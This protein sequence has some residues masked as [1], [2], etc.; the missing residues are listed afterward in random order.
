MIGVFYVFLQS[1][2]VN[3]RR[4][5]GLCH[6]RFLPNPFLFV[7]YESSYC[8]TVYG[9]STDRAAKLTTNEDDSEETE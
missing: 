8:W 1:C 3:T 2:V 6:D 4:I 9:L 5:P 7:I